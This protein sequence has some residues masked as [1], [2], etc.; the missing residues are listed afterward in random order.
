MFHKTI[1]ASVAALAMIV[2]ASPG[3]PVRADAVSDFYGG[4]TVTIVLGNGPGRTY[5]LYARLL[6]NNMSRHIPGKPTI[7]IQYMRGAGG[8]K[9]T[10]YVYNAALKDGTVMATLF[11]SLPLLQKVR[12]K[13][14]KYDSLKFN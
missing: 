1:F 6:A 12:T 13:A 9:A 7:V 14:A 4:K 2:A 8:L 11:A 3:S 5:D 10:T